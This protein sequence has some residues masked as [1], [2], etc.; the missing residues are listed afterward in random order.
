MVG[1]EVGEDDHPGQCA[2]MTS[3]AEHEEVGDA[4]GDE[5]VKTAIAEWIVDEY[6]AGY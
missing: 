3:E 4:G 1:Y 5:G 2:A 6:D